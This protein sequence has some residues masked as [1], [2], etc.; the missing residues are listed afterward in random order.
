MLPLTKLTRIATLVSIVLLSFVLVSAALAGAAGAGGNPLFAPDLPQVE[1]LAPAIVMTKTVSANPEVCGTADFITVVPGANVRYC[2][3]VT[4]TGA[5]TVTNHTLV[6]DQLGTLLDDELI[7]I[8]PGE[9]YTF[10]TTDQITD[11][12]TN[13]AVWTAGDGLG[14]SD[15]ASDSATVATFDP[16]MVLSKTA[17][18]TPG[19]CPGSNSIEIIP[20]TPVN[21]CYEVTNTGPVTLTLHTLT[22]NRLGLLIPLDTFIEIPP[23]SSFTFSTTE[24]ITQSVTNIG[25]WSAEDGYGHL[26]GDNDNASVTVLM[27]SIILTKTVSAVP[28]ICAPTDVVTVTAGSSVT[29]CYDIQNTGQVTVTGHTLFDDVLGALFT[30]TLTSVGPGGTMAY[31]TTVPVNVDTVNTATW[32]AE[33]PFGNQAQGVDSAGVNVT[34]PGIDLIKTVTAD[35]GNCPGAN[36]EIVVPGSTVTYCFELMNTGTTTLTMH[37]LVDDHLGVLLSDAEIEIAP[38]GSHFISANIMITQPVTN[39]ATWTATDEFE[40]ELETSD[41]AVVE[42]TGVEVDLVKTVGTDLSVCAPTSEISV[43]AGT[44][45]SYCFEITNTGQVTFT[46]H[47]LVDSQFGLLLNGAVIVVPPAGKFTFTETAVINSSVTNNANWTATDLYGNTA[48]ASD[49]ATVN[50]VAAGILVTPNSILV[51]QPV[52]QVTTQSLFIT[53]TGTTGLTWSSGENQVPGGAGLGAP[54]ALGEEVFQFDLGAMLANEVLLGVEF[55]GSSFWVT[56]GGTTHQSEE[57]LLYQI[58]RSGALLNVYPQPTVSEFGWR[59]LAFD[60]TFLYSSDSSF[61]DR[62]DPTTGM[63]TGIPIPSPINP[64][65][66]IAFDPATG[67]FWVST[68]GSPIFEIEGNGNIVNTFPSIGVNIYGLAWDD[69][70]PGGPFLWAWTAGN[71]PRAIQ[72]DP[73]T[74]TQTGVDFTSAP[75]PGGIGGGGAAITADLYPDQLV[76]IGLHQAAPDTIVGYDLGI[77]TGICTA[78]EVTWLSL[79]PGAGV[80]PAGNGIEA[81]V[82]FDSTGLAPGVYNGHLCIASSDMDNPLVVVPVRMIAGFDNQA[83]IPVIFKEP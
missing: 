40:T 39:L 75:V 79:S 24:I 82:E 70:T 20:G 46:S 58:D 25:I 63:T 9:S 8:P 67:N 69:V 59:D 18:T 14:G 78:N 83:F 10:S 81:E 3:E 33:E 37:T 43:I 6:D 31:S 41:S 30:D 50:L 76:L 34:T 60:G 15:E 56:A 61:I 54:A 16:D 4:N 17:T 48:V 74:G 36:T 71:P 53:N 11:E 5:V 44:T 57:N 38:G 77:E 66:A 19:E 80:I 42:I 27:P 51:S 26:T 73:D 23:A 64:A 29:Y 45:V 1:I 62:I 21:Y 68:F 32:T 52:D 72:I 49:S 35:L 28:G 65:R 47:T 22:D 2:Y 13:F 55:D 12:V 7:D